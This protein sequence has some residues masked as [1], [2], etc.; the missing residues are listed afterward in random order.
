MAVLNELSNENDDDGW[1]GNDR[2][3]APAESQLC[4]ET[5]EGAEREGTRA[6]RTEVTVAAGDH[7]G[8]CRQMQVLGGSVFQ[9]C[10][11]F[12]LFKVQRSFAAHH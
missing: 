7:N 1:M 9:R 11:L 8:R 3:F 12:S 2:Y 5:K 6:A 10:T 4:N